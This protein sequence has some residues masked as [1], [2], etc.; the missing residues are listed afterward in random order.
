MRKKPLKTICIIMSAAMMLTACGSKKAA[1]YK[2]GGEGYTTVS[3]VDGITF[4]IPQSFSNKATAVTRIANDQEFTSDGI[5]SYAN[6]EDEY[7]FFCMDELVILANKG[8]SYNFSGTEIKEN[9]LS[10]SSVIDSMCSK[11]G[12][13]F[14]Y[15][16]STEDSVYKL[17][18][19][20][21]ENVSITTELYG[22][23]VGRLA[24]IEDGTNEWSVLAGVKGSSLSEISKEQL[25]V[26]DKVVSSMKATHGENVIQTNAPDYDVV[27]NDL[28]AIGDTA[29]EVSSPETDR[30]IEPVEE[31]EEA[32]DTIEVSEPDTEEDEVILEL[33]KPEEVEEAAE[34]ATAI[35]GTPEDPQ[36]ELESTIAEDEPKTTEP[37]TTEPVAEESAVVAASTASDEKIR[38]NQRERDL[39]KEQVYSSD[40]YSLLKTGNY[41]IMVNSDSDGSLKYPVVHLKAVY[42]GNDA[43]DIVKQQASSTARYDYFEAPPGYSW[44]VAEY[45]I[46][47]AEASSEH[48]LDVRMLGVDGSVL[49]YRGVPAPQRTYYVDYDIE[50]DSSSKTLKNIKVFYAVPNGCKEYVLK[51]GDGEVGTE[52]EHYSAYYHVGGT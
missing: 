31:T 4:E 17:I 13:K 52:T 49:K 23:Y 8:T 50:D 18:G 14:S 41:G 10:S 46:I 48:E 2:E 7:M 27:I 28:E 38:T 24:V 19:D 26:I 51:F 16:E 9:A 35:E 15:T 43:V 22:D 5:Y 25:A 40:I 33:T 44:Q 37:A 1:S 6:G 39:T 47:Y 20:V 32:P 45:D 3:S 21:A 30:S 42:T 12:K 29:D 34:A 36:F 11:L